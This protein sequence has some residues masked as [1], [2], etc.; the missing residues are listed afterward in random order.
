M[1]HKTTLL[2]DQRGAIILMAVFMA[3]FLVGCLWYLIG[4]GDAIIYRQKMQDG[5]DAA[6]YV[7][8]VYHARGMNIIALMNII[9]AALLA[10]LIALKVAEIIAGIVAAVSCVICAIV[11]FGLP[12]CPVC[13]TTTNL[14]IQLQTN[15]IPAAQKTVDALLAVLST[16]QKGVA[17]V[18]P[19]LGAAEALTQVKNYA[20][21][22][23]S[24]Y[25]LSVSMKP[26]GTRL[27]LPVQEMPFAKLCG[28]AGELVAD[29]VGF[30]LPPAF[31]RFLR[32]AIEGITTKASKFFC[33]N[34]GGSVGGGF[35]D[36]ADVDQTCNDT[37]DAADQEQENY[38]T[39]LAIAT[40]N[41]TTPPKPPAPF[42]LADCKK[43]L[44]DEINNPKPPTGGTPTTSS[45]GQ[46]GKE[47][48]SSAENGDDYFGVYSFVMGDPAVVKRSDKGV[49][50]AA[51]GKASSG[52]GSAAQIFSVG[53]NTG[54]AKA[55]FYYDQTRADTGG[56][57]DW[58]SYKDDA[59]W[60]LRW[61]ARLRRFRAPTLDVGGGAVNL[62]NGL[63][64]SFIVH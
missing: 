22:V 31:K 4:V 57:L 42:D 14:V 23:K 20:P 18:A 13:L 11:P 49:K 10:V 27:G 47:M 54:F 52:G 35:S 46:S 19:W 58:A 5:A 34:G 40:A 39:A 29:I 62:L 21:T 24:S 51:W 53:E 1:R 38:Q 26:T 9:M 43:K 15:I 32:G 6:A 30:W 55:D 41:G 7:S 63:T 50:I 12:A 8:A 48:F 25:A 56:K 37:K 61:R 45:K 64:D 33:G 44:K 28:K 59:L 2:S 16:A 36:S 60:N 3:S 17:A